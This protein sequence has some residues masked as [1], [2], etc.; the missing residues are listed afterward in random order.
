MTRWEYLRTQVSADKIKD[1]DTQI[2]QLGRQGWELVDTVFT[3][4][5]VH[6]WFKRPQGSSGQ[7]GDK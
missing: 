4:T 2:D 5:Y 7:E 6:F 1:I 3:Q